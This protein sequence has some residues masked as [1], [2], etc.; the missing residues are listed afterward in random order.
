M[1]GLLQSVILAKKLLEEILSK[2]GHI[3]IKLTPS[4]WKQ[5]WRLI[6]FTLVIDDFGVKYQ[7]KEHSDHLVSVLK[8]HY[9]NQKIGIV[10]NMLE[11]RLIFIKR[12]AKCTSLFRDMSNFH[13][14]V[15]VQKNNQVRRSTILTGTT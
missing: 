5:K 3:Q 12:A 11:S 8:E 1:H 7:G 4:F 15:P 2:H 10:K 14:A 13:A 6:F 9:E